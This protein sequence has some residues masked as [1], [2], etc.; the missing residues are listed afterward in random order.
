MSVDFY[1]PLWRREGIL[2]MWHM[3]VVLS[4]TFLFP[5]NNSRTP[6][7]TFLK[8]VHISV[9]GSSWT[10]LI[11]GSLGQMPRSPGSK[12]S[13]LFP[14]NFSRTPWPTFLKHGPHIR[15]GQQMNHINFGVTRSNAKVTRVKGVKTVSDQFL[16]NSMT[17]LPQT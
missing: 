8:L 6:Q 12:V 7:P 3:S 1:A 17:Y 10:I 14:I 5:I 15:P 16:E 11:L 2:H 13:K 4:V 9:L